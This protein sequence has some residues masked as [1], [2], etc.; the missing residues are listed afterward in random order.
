M[1]RVLIQAGAEINKAEE[2]GE[3][4]AVHRRAGG[5][6]GGGAGADRGGRGRGRGGARRC[7]SVLYYVTRR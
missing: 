2:N 1:V 6:R 7:T 4:P 5:P 3:T